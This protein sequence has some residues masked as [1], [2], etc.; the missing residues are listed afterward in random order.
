MGRPGRRWLTWL[1]TGTA[2]SS[3]R[4]AA[5]SSARSLR[6]TPEDEQRLAASRLIHTSIYSGID[7]LLPRLAELAPVSYDFS[8]APEMS[9]IQTL[10]P[11]ISVACFSGAHLGDKDRRALGRRVLAHG[12][13]VAL[14]TAGRAGAYAYTTV[15]E[16]HEAIVPTSVVDALGAGDSFITGFLHHWTL[17][18]SVAAAMAEGARSGAAACRFR[19]LRPPVAVARNRLPPSPP[20]STR[21]SISA[22]R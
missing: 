11:H 5:A 9:A 12:P 20:G 10:L 22:T 13:E 21:A 18:A 8:E 16:H 4:T 19:R 6:L 15:E 7:H 3:A 1:A 17:R 14:V 2:S